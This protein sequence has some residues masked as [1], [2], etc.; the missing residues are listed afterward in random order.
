MTTRGV[1]VVTG[2]DPAHP[3]A[4][5]V[6]PRGEGWEIA[7]ER[8]GERWMFSLTAGPEPWRVRLGDE[9]LVHDWE[10]RAGGATRLTVRAATHDLL[11]EREVVHR[12]AVATR[13]GAPATRV[14]EVRS[15]MPGLVLLVEVAE[16]ARVEAGE[17]LMI[18][19]A[20]KME[21]EITAPIQGVVRDLSVASGQAVE[22]GAL[23]CRIE[24]VD[25]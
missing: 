16:G 18:V 25:R 5:T 6:A 10:P 15:P 13:A 4:V 11:V 20:M 14:R 21:N 1:Y 19:E 22:R 3:Y 9:P 24:A 7:V 2:V 12:L 23:L 8:G 17:G